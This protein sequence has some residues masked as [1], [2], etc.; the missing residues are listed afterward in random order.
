M[1]HFILND[2]PLAAQT[3]ESKRLAQFYKQK[4]Q[5][6]DAKV[7]TTQDEN[8]KST[9]IRQLKECEAERNIY[10]EECARLN[11]VVRQL[12]SDIDNLRQFGGAR[13]EFNI[14]EQQKLSY[15]D[16]IKQSIAEQTITLLKYKSELQR[17]Y[18]P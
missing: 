5:K 3:N 4:M 17:L 15:L 8:N 12:R 6:L 7:A 14:L 10:F 13:T 11:A 9:K 1:Q 18:A 16:E 2:K